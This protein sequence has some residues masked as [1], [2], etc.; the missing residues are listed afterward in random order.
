MHE[1]LAQ[2]GIRADQGLLVAGHGLWSWGGGGGGGVVW[3]GLREV[4]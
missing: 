1:T 3:E 4:G 2:V